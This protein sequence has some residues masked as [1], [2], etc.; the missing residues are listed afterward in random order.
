MAPIQLRIRD[1]NSSASHTPPVAIKPKAPAPST[2]DLS[3]KPHDIEFL[4]LDP[5]LLEAIRVLRRLGFQ[6]TDEALLERAKL[7]VTMRHSGGQ[8]STKGGFLSRIF[9]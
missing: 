6:G 8:G 7:E 1:K 3:L 5:E 4:Q 2:A 9:S